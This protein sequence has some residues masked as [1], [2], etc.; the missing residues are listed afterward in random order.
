MKSYTGILILIVLGSCHLR[1]EIP[2]GWNT[3]YAETISA[4]ASAQQPALIY[5]TAS[6]CGPCKLMS[7]ITL[8]DPAIAQTIADLPHAA[9]DIDEH[10]DIA[11]KHHVNAVPTFVLLSTAEN[12]T[13]RTTGFQATGDFLQW[14]TNSIAETKAAMVRQALAKK[15]LAE[16]DQLLAATETNS[17]QLAAMK[18]FALG[19]ERETAVV[20]AAADR[21]KA[22]AMRHP[23][24]LLDG[25]N[26]PRLATRIQVANALQ[27]KIGDEFD[28]DPWSDAAS[29]QKSIIVWRE[30]LTNVE[31]SVPNRKSAKN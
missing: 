10:P 11:S 14:L 5:F 21:L 7:R 13:K 23:A 3:N 8:T 31:N 4:A 20:Q 2:A 12:E 28:V 24:A 18:L 30:K 1:A 15:N 6:W 17:I 19:D 22:I 26:D 25:L 27:S 9:V 16:V 29:R